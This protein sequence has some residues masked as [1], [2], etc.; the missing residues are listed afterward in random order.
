[1]DDNALLIDGLVDTG[2]YDKLTSSKFFKDV[3]A[4]SDDFIGKVGSLIQSYNIRW[5]RDPLHQWS[6]QWEYPYV[7]SQAQGLDSKDVRIIDLGAGMSFLPYYLKQRLGLPNIIAVDYDKSLE[8]LYHR[9][10]Q[11][12]G[13]PVEFMDGD[14]R[15]LHNI[16]DESA[17]FVYSVSVLEHTD[18]YKKVLEEIHRILKP[19][20]KLS[21]TFDISIDGLDDIPRERARELLQNLEAVF[22]LG[23]DLDLDTALEHPE[24]VTSGK[25]AQRDKKLMPWKYPSINVIKHLA[26]HRTPGKRYKHLTFCCLTVA[27][28]TK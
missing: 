13:D 6:R 18:S 23:L 9:V 21:L 20:G 15:N 17:D 1:M 28:K 11:T 24:L 5:V 8:K 7:I 26:K 14:M 19:G 16:E 25:M 3:E 4:F 22:G 2:Q 12:M 27:K 10:N